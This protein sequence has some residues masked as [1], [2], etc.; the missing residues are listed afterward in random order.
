MS[1]G[2]H[3]RS[4]TWYIWDRNPFCSD[5]PSFYKRQADAAGF[6]GGPICCHFSRKIPKIKPCQ[7][8]SLSVLV[9]P[10]VSRLLTSFLWRALSPGNHH[11]FFFFGRIGHQERQVTWPKPVFQLKEKELGLAQ[12]PLDDWTSVLHREK[13]GAVRGKRRVCGEEKNGLCWNQVLI[14]LMTLL[15]MNAAIGQSIEHI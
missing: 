8:L 2:L 13:N 6:S 5:D 3:P 1:L 14:C 11:F 7:E 4:E 15:L 9:T 12:G 10:H